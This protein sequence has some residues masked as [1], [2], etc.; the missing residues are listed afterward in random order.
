MGAGETGRACLGHPRV[1]HGDW[2]EHR[3]VALL[4]SRLAEPSHFDCSPSPP[5]IFNVIFE[6]CISPLNPFQ[7]MK[8]C[9]FH[10][11]RRMYGFLPKSSFASYTENDTLP[12]QVFVPSP[13]LSSVCA[14]QRQFK[15]RR[16]LWGG[17]GH[18]E[19][20]Q[21]Y[22]YRMKHERTDMQ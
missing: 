18:W 16:A 1:G 11:S 10:S 13:P 3:L 22:I 14:I 8:Q 5:I 9:F 20:A 7:K 17:E 21:I 15:R 19:G 12:R 4:A 2:G 6:F